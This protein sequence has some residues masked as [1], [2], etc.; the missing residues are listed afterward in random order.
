MTKRIFV[1]LVALALCASGC[2]TVERRESFRAGPDLV[3]KTVSSPLEDVLDN[4]PGVKW[5][6]ASP[7]RPQTDY[8]AIPGENSYYLFRDGVQFIDENSALRYK[9]TPE[10]FELLTIEQRDGMYKHP[11][12][13]A[14]AFAFTCVENHSIIIATNIVC[15]SRA[16]D[17][18]FVV[19]DYYRK[20][21]FLKNP[22][23]IKTIINFMLDEEEMKYYFP[24]RY[25][26][27]FEVKH[28]T[29]GN[30]TD[31]NL[32][33]IDYMRERS[34][35]LREVIGYAVANYDIRI[36]DDQGHP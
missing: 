3:P 20:F 10:G 26:E 32:L 4:M 36:V 5:E 19:F 34:E 25:N 15:G 1:V 29:S 7:S 28:R 2:R 9:Q 30:I 18:D 6:I 24:Y 21:R 33:W 13:P 35:L 12:C 16:C 23:A 31:D 8:L 11:I 14:D 17:Y 27:E 22:P